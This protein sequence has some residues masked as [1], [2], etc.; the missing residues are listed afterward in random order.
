M[1]KPL[2][3]TLLVLISQLPPAGAFISAS[4]P[5]RRTGQELIRSKLFKD[6]RER[7]AM[8]MAQGQKESL[9]TIASVV[10][11]NRLVV[12]ELI[13]LGGTVLY[14]NDRLD[15]LSAKVPTA[16]V[17]ILV[18]FKEVESAE[19]DIDQPI[20]PAPPAATNDSENE[21]E[22]SPV[23]SPPGPDTP[24]A[25]P[26]L[27]VRD[28][29]VT[30]LTAKNPTFDG[31]GVAVA[32]V[33]FG[34]DLLTP[35]LQTAKTIDGKE[36][37]KIIDYLTSTE[38]G[39]RE[40]PNW[41]KM[42][43]SVTAQSGVL[44]HDGTSYRSPADDVYR[45]GLLH[46]PSIRATD[47]APEGSRRENGK[48]AVLWD[49]R[50]N[51]VWVDTN[52]N[53]SFADEKA[54]KEYAIHHDVGLFGEDDPETPI[55]ETV[56]FTVQIRPSEK[57]VNICFGRDVHGTSSAGAAVGKRFFGGRMSS[58]A[59]EAQLLFIKTGR[60]IRSWIKAM[61]MA[62]EDPRVE[63]ISHQTGNITWRRQDGRAVDSIVIGR[64]MRHYNKLFVFPAENGT[65]L[66]SIYDN[67]ALRN[68][69]TVSGYI[70]KD[71]WLANYGVNVSR[72]DYQIWSW[73]PGP[74][75]ELKP[76]LLSI[77]S[78]V[79]TAPASLPGFSLKKVFS[80]PPGYRMG[81][82]TSNS[83]PVTLGV[84]A[85]LISGAKQAKVRYDAE[86]LRRAMTSTARYLP[87]Y[88]A[89]QQG[90]GLL[91]ADAAWQR[92]KQLSLVNQFDNI[93][94]VAPVRTSVSHFL[95][96]PNEGLGIYEREGWAVG[97][98][99]TRSITFQRTSG[100]AE[101]VTYRL[102]W[103][104]NDG[105]FSCD[106]SITL[107]LNTPVRLPV[108]I[109][110]K[111]SGAHSAVLNLVNSRLPSP[112]YQVLNTIV[113]ADEFTEAAGYTIEQ[114]TYLDRP[115]KKSFYFFVPENASALNI[116]WKLPSKVA[117]LYVIQPT[118]RWVTTTLG[119]SLFAEVKESSRAYP[120]PPSGVWEVVF[121]NDLDIRRFDE[122][123]PEQLTPTPLTL[124]LALFG[125]DLN[126][127][128]ETGQRLEL[129]KQSK[130]LVE[131]H[132]R[133]AS[134][135]SSTVEMNL[136]EASKA[137]DII[138]SG[139]QRVYEIAVPAQS[140]LV[141]AS[142]DDASTKAADID[143]YL[144]DCTSGKCELRGRAKEKSAAETVWALNPKPG[145]W[146]V[147]VDCFAAPAG[148]VSFE[149]QSLYSHSGSVQR[150]Y[151]RRGQSQSWTDSISIF[152]NSESELRGS[153]SAIARVTTDD[154]IRIQYLDNLQSPLSRPY[155]SRE[156]VLL[157]M[158]IISLDKDPRR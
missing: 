146:K 125:V 98:R 107:P 108:R 13:K 11:R 83:A 44:M 14:R 64:L 31:R 17:D 22:N 106:D 127:R 156:P 121:A 87:E 21:V 144:F 77:T 100:V 49:E 143:L 131:Y 158:K 93:H 149:Y 148:G 36:V 25:N 41:V 140:D 20:P 132:N 47:R 46:E 133:F 55:R 32:V 34:L 42:D 124:K 84:A 66:N 72:N 54:M 139:S 81:A 65:G 101:P 110:P 35:E 102:T 114:D 68:V 12:Q 130:Y 113:A 129:G 145:K 9:L 62:T 33:D 94:S 19:V 73:G 27:P 3:T 50:S 79:S 142:I 86:R 5:Q 76:D 95:A 137:R 69:L 115:G 126:V 119:E 117:Y 82:G 109:Q 24:F 4:E 136:G 67:A 75:G 53:R 85:Q 56:G 88:A 118:G 39:D 99:E 92:L 153:V 61:I 152:P 80:L 6:S 30:D 105:T 7:L 58:P 128:P 141:V 59:P 120:N 74:G 43:Q 116:S 135:G 111:S 57:Y 89:H 45:I 18:A 29:G 147:V 1:L 38:P 103:I 37:P 8:A 23:G 40:D 63:V 10:G 51:T 122:S 71:T 123:R 104:G 48:F 60:S 157:G 155:I 138:G 70:S 97:L 96:T 78:L 112:A 91:R 16:K 26:F 2:I 150:R 151:D 52:Q 15:Y 154:V 134:L 90:N 28:I